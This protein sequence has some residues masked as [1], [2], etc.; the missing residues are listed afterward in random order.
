[1]KLKLLILGGAA[2]ALTAGGAVAKTHKA[3]ASAGAYAPPSQPIPYDQMDNYMKGNAKTRASIVAMGSGANTGTA[4]NTA[5]TAP[6]NPAPPP[7]NPAPNTSAA[8]SAPA[9][10]DNMGGSSA[11]PPAPPSAG[12]TTNAPAGTPQSGPTGSPSPQ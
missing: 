5:A 2:L 8:A 9:T 12:G 7:V 4:A 1:M 11:T 3:A 6:V 10:Q